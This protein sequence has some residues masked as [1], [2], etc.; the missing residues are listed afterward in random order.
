MIK[1]PPG[2]WIEVTTDFGER[3]IPPSIADRMAPLVQGNF[4]R[5]FKTANR[6]ERYVR[7]IKRAIR[8][9]WEAGA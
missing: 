6:D 8:C 4:D 1:D 2:H 9:E 7:L 5:R 3:W